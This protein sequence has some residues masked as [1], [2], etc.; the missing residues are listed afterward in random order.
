[1]VIG[2]EFALLEVVTTFVHDIAGQRVLAR[3]TIGAALLQA[4]GELVTNCELFS[5]SAPVDIS[6]PHSYL[7]T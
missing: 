6:L 2:D 5:S 4:A 1:L 7:S 3:S